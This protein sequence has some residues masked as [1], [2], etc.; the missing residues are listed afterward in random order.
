[1]EMKN[2]V[3]RST[4][5]LMRSMRRRPPRGEHQF[6]PA[7]ERMLMTL[8]DN[9]G[10][11]SRDLCEILDVRPSSLSELLGKMEEKGLV[12]RQISEEDKR[13]AI[14]TLTEEGA[15]AAA[16][17]RANFEQKAAEFSACFTDE[18]AAKFCELSDKLAAHLESLPG[19]EGHEGEGPFCHHRGPGFGP[20]GPHGHH[21]HHGPH[22]CHGHH[23]PFGKR[24]EF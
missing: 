12:S 9:E 6:P 11:T 21:G 3:M 14:V 5:K 22:G 18:E 8:S 24:P 17:I 1:M 7:V 4:L 20:C 2:D 19:E 10:A 13:A 16:A 23:G 15:A